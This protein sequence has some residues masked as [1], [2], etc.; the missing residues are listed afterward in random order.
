MFGKKKQMVTAPTIV[1][2]ST[3]AAKPE[4]AKKLSP[5]DA[6][7]GEIEQLTPEKSISYKLPPIFGDCLAIVVLNPEYPGK[8]KKYSMLTEEFTGGK[9]SGKKRRLWDAD[10]AKDI[11]KWI[12]ER[13]GKPFGESGS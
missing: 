2:T 4:K 9:P 7:A 12:L 11:A 5:Q 13:N 6:L 8:G 10:K 1:G 3:A